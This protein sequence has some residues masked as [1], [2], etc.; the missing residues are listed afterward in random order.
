[1]QV[2]EPGKLHS[3]KVHAVC[4]SCG[5]DVQRALKKKRATL[6]DLRK[7]LH[8]VK[9]KADKAEDIYE[10][11]FCL[12]ALTRV[13]AASCGLALFAACALAVEVGGEVA[14]VAGIIVAGYDAAILLVHVIAGES[15]SSDAIRLESKRG[16]EK[17]LTAVEKHGLKDISKTL[18]LVVNLAM[19]QYETVKGIMKMDSNGNQGLRSARAVVQREILK[20]DHKIAALDTQIKTCRSKVPI[21]QH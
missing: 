13:L 2:Q 5:I 7:Y 1:M 20:L 12:E 3:H 15:A 17:L 10:L 9:V 14:L 16:A 11:T 21:Q 19:W 18:G 8:S 6:T 4:T